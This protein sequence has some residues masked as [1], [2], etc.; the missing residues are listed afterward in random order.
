MKRRP[1]FITALIQ[2]ELMEAERASN[3][4]VDYIATMITEVHTG[5]RIEA[6]KKVNNQ[7]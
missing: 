5:V 7:N 3:L 4:D 6:A 2:A 1:L